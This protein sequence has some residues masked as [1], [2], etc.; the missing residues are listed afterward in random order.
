MGLPP[1]PAPHEASVAAAQSQLTMATSDTGP[2]PLSA[3]A[4]VFRRLVE[5]IRDYAIFML[6]PEGVIASWNNGAQLIKQYTAAE[7]IGQHFRCMT[8][9]RGQ[10]HDRQHGG[11]KNQAV[12]FRAQPS[13]DNRDRQ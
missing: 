8:H 1:I 11:E 4:E 3:N 12:L 13:R 10:R 5:S 9:F 6:T 2:P 7:A